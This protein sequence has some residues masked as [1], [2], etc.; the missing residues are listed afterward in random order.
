MQPGHQD[1]LS[2]MQTCADE[3]RGAGLHKVAGPDPCVCGASLF[4]YWCLSALQE[5]SRFCKLG[6]R[7]RE[8]Q[9][10]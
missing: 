10:L 8:L 6:A 7:S 2:C 4:D 5:M 1:L 9:E 3:D